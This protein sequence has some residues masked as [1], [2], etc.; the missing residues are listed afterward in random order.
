ML[1]AVVYSVVVFFA[2][3]GKP[4]AN[5]LRI[6]NEMSYQG[7]VV[8]SFLASKEN[9]TGFLSPSLEMSRIA[10]DFDGMIFTFQTRNSSYL[11]SLFRIVLVDGISAI[12]QQT[13]MTASDASQLY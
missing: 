13:T 3:V 8:L 6:V 9:W 5:A 12:V 4:G 7:C 10:I 11:I 2:R 1:T